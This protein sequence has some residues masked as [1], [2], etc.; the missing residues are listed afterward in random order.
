MGKVNELMTW[1]GDLLVD[2]QDEVN[3]FAFDVEE[4]L[5]QKLVKA[6]SEEMDPVV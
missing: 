4:F 3:T 6:V 1:I 2:T 5:N